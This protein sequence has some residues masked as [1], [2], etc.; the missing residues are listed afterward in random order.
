MQSSSTTILSAAGTVFALWIVEAFVFTVVAL[1]LSWLFGFG[2]FAFS[3]SI[4]F[5]FFAPIL[6]GFVYAAVWGFH[7]IVETWALR[8][9]ALTL[10]RRN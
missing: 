9:A 7:H 1:T 6:I 3:E 10:A 5:A 2:I 4:W 8:R